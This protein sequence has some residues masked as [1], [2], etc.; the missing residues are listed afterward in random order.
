[1]AM[2]KDRVITGT[3]ISIVYIA[4]FLLAMY[5][6]P[7]FF[8]VFIFALAVCGV[9]EMSRAI[10]HV[11]SPPIFVIGLVQVVVGFAAFWFAQYY[12]KTNASGLTAYFA[13]LAVM[14]IFTLIF[15]A[16]SKEYV[17]GNAMSTIF[18]MMYPSAIL[19]FSVG[20]N[21]FMTAE[22]GISVLAS[23]PY[24]NAGI[25]L[26]FLVPAFTDVFAYQIGSAI[27]GKKLCPSISPNKTISGAIGGL[28]GGVVGAGIVLFLTF[29]AVEYSV[30]IF[31]LAMLTDTWATTIVNFIILGLFGSVFDQAGD[32]VA[33]Y[34]KRKSGI[35]DYSNL[36]PGH[37]GIL[38]RID[39]FMFCG[40]LYYMYFAVMYVL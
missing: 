32:L 20:I 38:D 37:G 21:Y 14:V 16:C 19:M 12:F 5:V 28:L 24:R 9:Y 27:K 11:M 23:L 13:V 2:K 15:T 17:K 25:A 29:F 40:V 7:I 6:H 34:V 18:V 33:S 26:M 4:V 31:G 36:L 22:L 10:S 30:N 8:D 3:F 35:K 39:G 1:M